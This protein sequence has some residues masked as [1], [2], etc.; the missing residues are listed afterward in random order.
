MSVTASVAKSEFGR[1]LETALHGGAVVITRHNAPRAVL[2]SVEQFNAMSTAD[3]TLDTLDHEFDALLDR[4]QTPA[5]RRGLKTA[6]AASG[7]DAGK[8]AVAAVRKRG[9]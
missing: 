6:F 9:R 1:V 3:T 7:N 4:L 2:I 5:V 8:A